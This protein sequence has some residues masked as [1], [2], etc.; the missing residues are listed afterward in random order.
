VLTYGVA[1]EVAVVHPLKMMYRGL[2]SWMEL[3]KDT[4][5]RHQSSKIMK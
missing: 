4:G 2:L 3:A 5:Y 1:K